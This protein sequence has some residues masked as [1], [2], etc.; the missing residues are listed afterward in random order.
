M[1]TISIVLPDN[2]R[3]ELPSGATAHD[4][5]RDIAEGL[6]R[7]VVVA[8]INGEVKDLRTPLSDGDAV[9]L[10]KA[11]SPEGLDTLRHSAEHIMATA[12]LS[13]FEGAQVTMG[14][15]NHDGEFYY[16]FD[17]GRPFTP[18]DIKKVEAAMKKLIKAKTPFSMEVVS[19]EAARARFAEAGQ[20]FKD[21]ILDWIP[22]DDVNIYTSGA[23][24]DLCR[25]PHL[26]HAGFIKAFKLLGASSAYWRG[27]A[28]RDA[29]QRI[30]GIAFASKD[31]LKAYV[32]RIEEAKKRDH[33][34]LGR[35][36][37]LFLV[38][39]KFDSHEYP[40]DGDVEMLVTGSINASALR[41]GKMRADSVLDD[42]LLDG[43]QALFAPRAVKLNGYN[44]TPTE[45]DGELAWDIKIRLY[46]GQIDSET[47][48]KLRELEAQMNERQAGGRIRL[49]HETRYTEEVGPGLAMWLPKGGRVRSIVEE[50]WRK[51][52]FEGGYE[53]V[54]SPHLAKSDLWKVSGHWDFYRE[55]MFSPMAVD[56]QEYVAKPMNCPF[57]ILMLKSKSRSYRDFPI[58]MAEL[59]TVYRYEMAGALHGLMRVRGFTQDDAHIF[60]RWDQL[61]TEV[62]RVIAFILKVLRT[63]GFSEFEVNLSTQPEKS[64]GAQEDWAKAEAALRRAVERTGLPFVVDEGG[65]AFYGPKIDIKL[66]D[67]LGRMWQC[68]TLQLDF[69]NP[70][71][72]HLSYV[73]AEG[74]Q[75]QPV[76]LHRALL[77]S[78]ERFIGILVEQYAGAFPMWL[79]PEQVR[80]LTI[81]DRH[82]EHAES[83]AD[84]L[85][86]NGIR[87]DVARSS[88]KIGAKIRAAQMDKVP[89]MLVVGDREVEQGGAA[90][91]LQD[92]GEDL[93]FMALDALAAFLVDKAAVPSGELEA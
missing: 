61:D 53:I 30:S 91:R 1:S 92:G 55:S 37:D 50:Q 79:A 27:D 32:H 10:F 83:L 72:F 77:G 63:F 45:E 23:F 7:V 16:D 67:C 51:M 49:L 59:G 84:A 14:P 43:V 6:A 31:A 93:G 71:R 86:G 17:I 2:S 15:K 80:V 35:E 90:V 41:D 81:A 64:V 4:L 88:D 75:E 69:N 8:K 56:G 74:Q 52:H 82:L 70:E 38:S 66:K 33:R 34:K 78:V 73:N 28:S 11:D 25:G 5:A 60:C 42:A 18:E 26:P 89:V 48:S 44:V 24:M 9:E 40:N 20:R 57:H 19:K 29:L 85:R 36:L 21:E 47:H 58:R 22:E 54:Y 68:S 12:V 39:D 46:C 76:M 3:R 65:G 62:D 13:L 87:V